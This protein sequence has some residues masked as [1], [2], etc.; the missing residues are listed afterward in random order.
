MY[1]VKRCGCRRIPGGRPSDGGNDRDIEIDG[2]STTRTVKSGTLF[3]AL[4]GSN[5]DGA[6]YIHKA[7]IRG[8]ASVISAKRPEQIRSAIIEAAPGAIEIEDRS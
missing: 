5:V 6:H 2:L 4:R 7:S 1:E 8:A 3:V